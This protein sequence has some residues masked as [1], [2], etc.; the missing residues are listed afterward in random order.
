MIQRIR[1]VNLLVKLKLELPPDNHKDYDD[2]KQAKDL[3]QEMLDQSPLAFEGIVSVTESVII[4]SDSFQ[5]VV[6][7]VQDED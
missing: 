1:T 5:D 4:E 3:F 2:P 7:D 6:I